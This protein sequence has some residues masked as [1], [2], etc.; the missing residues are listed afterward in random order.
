[1]GKF[2]D[3]QE[4]FDAERD[5]ILNALR[6]DEN[7]HMILRL[8]GALAFRTHCPQYGYI[9]DD[10]GRQFTDI[11]FASYPRYLKDISRLLG[12]LGGRR[13]SIALQLDHGETHLDD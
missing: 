7:R 11:D 9:Q 1:M 6:Q 10:L 12:E 3:L 13:K 4:D 2:G 8:L 5:R